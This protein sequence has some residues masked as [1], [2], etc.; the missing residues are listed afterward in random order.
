MFKTSLTNISKPKLQYYQLA[1]LYKVDDYSGPRFSSVFLL[2]FQHCQPC[3]ETLLSETLNMTL[4]AAIDTKIKLNSKFKILDAY[5]GP[6]LRSQG[7]V[8]L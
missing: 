8:S 7:S 4:N 5:S 6:G 2:S 1:K 3:G